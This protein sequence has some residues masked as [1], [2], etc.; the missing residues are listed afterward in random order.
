MQTL[1]KKI[2]MDPRFIIATAQ[3]DVSPAAGP[4]TLNSDLLI[5][6]TINPPIIPEMIPD[7]TGAP[8][9]IEMP[10]QRGNA[11]K[12]TVMLAFKSCFRKERNK[13]LILRLDESFMMYKFP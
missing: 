7:V 5:N 13:N 4:L 10:R 8:E 12:K 2:S 6:E 9:A 11:T 1:R 3:M